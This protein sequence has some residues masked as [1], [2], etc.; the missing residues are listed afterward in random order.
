MTVERVDRRTRGDLV[1]IDRYVRRHEDREAWSRVRSLGYRV[2]LAT[3]AERP[4][5]AQ[6]A[7]GAIVTLA[8]RRLRQ[9]DG[10]DAA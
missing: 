5:V 7:A 9:I 2:H 3:V 8:D 6:H 4:D 1:R 10:G